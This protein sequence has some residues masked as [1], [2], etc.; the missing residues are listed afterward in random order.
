MTNMRTLRTLRTILRRLLFQRTLLFNL[1]RTLLFQVSEGASGQQALPQSTSRHSNMSSVADVTES[2]EFRSALEAPIATL[3]SLDEIDRQ[4]K[5]VFSFFKPQNR[6]NWIF[7]CGLKWKVAEK[8]CSSMWFTF[9][10]NMNFYRFFFHFSIFRFLSFF[11]FPILMNFSNF[12][13]LTIF[14]NVFSFWTIF[15][16]VQLFTFDQF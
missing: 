15:Y 14:F 5:N 9:F 13:M 3:E 4:V 2:W 16:F 12:V 10:R 1:L 7:Y 6:T 11:P 8:N